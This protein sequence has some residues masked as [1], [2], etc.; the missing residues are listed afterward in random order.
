MKSNPAI[1]AARRPD[2]VRLRELRDVAER[3]Y[4]E[5]TI[6]QTRTDTQVLVSRL[7]GG[8]VAVAFR[9][10]SSL[11]DWITNAQFMT[12]ILLSTT[13]HGGISVHRVHTGFLA[14]FESVAVDLTHA[15]GEALREA[16]RNYPDA[17][18][19]V[20]GHSLGG[21]LALLGGMEFARQKL[22]LALVVTFGAPRVGNKA[23]ARMFNKFIGDRTINVVNEGDPVPLL[24]TLLMGYRD[25]GHELFL[26]RNGAVKHDPFIGWEIFKDAFGMWRNWRKH[27]L[28][29][30]S[31]HLLGEYQERMEKQS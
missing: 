13:R 2:W 4:S 12:T 27:Q 7:A 1:I 8:D 20:T 9:G 25:C 5:A 31:N 18:L 29:L 16:R 6:I 19:H 22:P 10:S 11:R 15:V 14:A 3:A 26:R 23:F 30:I 24:P 28:G 21:A 17:R